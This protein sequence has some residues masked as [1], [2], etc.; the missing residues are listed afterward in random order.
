MAK[1]KPSSENDDPVAIDIDDA[2]KDDQKKEESA[3]MKDYLRIFSYSD[4]WDWLL[5]GLGALAAIAAG[6][7]LAL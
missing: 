3:G 4:R 5:N 6:S 7:S 1:E 2:S